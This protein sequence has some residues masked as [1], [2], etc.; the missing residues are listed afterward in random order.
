[1]SSHKILLGSSDSIEFEAI[2]I[3]CILL[4]LLLRNLLYASVIV[5]IMSRSGVLLYHCVHREKSEIFVIY[6]LKPHPDIKKSLKPQAAHM[7]FSVK[8]QTGQN[9]RGIPQPV[10]M[11]LETQTA[12]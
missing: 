11:L 8:P 4:Y 10:E 3:T 1:M 2:G 9:N 7:T 5:I 12:T 6:V